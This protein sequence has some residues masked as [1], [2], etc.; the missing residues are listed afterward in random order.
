[1]RRVEYLQTYIDL[2]RIGTARASANFALAQKLVFFS[3]LPEGNGSAA[4]ESRA[5]HSPRC[6]YQ[7]CRQLPR[8]RREDPGSLALGRGELTERTAC[9]GDALAA[10]AAHRDPTAARTGS[11]TPAQ[12]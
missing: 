7:R 8:R 2:C 6:R 12:P 11:Q 9:V 5:S 10:A 3:V 1:M 4:H